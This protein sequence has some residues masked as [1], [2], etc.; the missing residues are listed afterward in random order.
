MGDMNLT[1]P[2]PPAVLAIHDGRGNT[3]VQLRP[4]GSIEYGLG[5]EP[6]AAAQLFWQAMAFHFPG[7]KCP[8]CGWPDETMEHAEH[9]EGPQ[10]T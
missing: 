9:D 5:Y 1:P 4:D 2:E 3:L 6:D 8:R 10:G 7:R